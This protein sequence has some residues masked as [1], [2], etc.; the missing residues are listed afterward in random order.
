[1]CF[2]GSVSTCINRCYITLVKPW[3]MHISPIFGKSLEMVHGLGFPHFNP[4]NPIHFPQIWWLVYNCFSQ[5]LMVIPYFQTH[6]E[7]RLLTYTSKFST[8]IPIYSH[9][10]P[11][12]ILSTKP[13]QTYDIRWVI[14]L[15]HII[16][17]II[18]SSIWLIMVDCRS[19]FSMISPCPDEATSAEVRSRCCRG[20]RGGVEQIS[21]CYC[22]T[23]YIYIYIIIYIGGFANYLLTCLLNLQNVSHIPRVW[24]SLNDLMSTKKLLL[25]TQKKPNVHKKVPNVH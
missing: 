1:M 13:L 21:P 12:K 9:W 19:H 11:H 3:F 16:Y 20:V 6:P 8:D 24:K 5:Y 7:I 25:S 17:S 14:S 10:Y 2:F 15:Y 18:N 23:L 22:H 4:L